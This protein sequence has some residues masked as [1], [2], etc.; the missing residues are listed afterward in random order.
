MPAKGLLIVICGID[1]SG[2]TLQTAMLRDRVRRAGRR[3]RTIEFPRYE[4]GFFGNL[5]ARY[6][7][8][9]F[10]KDPAA[11][12]PYLA[13]LPFAC[14]RW[15]ALPVLD[16]WL[17]AGAV[18]ISNRYVPANLAHQGGKITSRARRREFLQWV[19][20]LEYGVFGL[21][22]PALHVWLDMPPR[23]A[24]TLILRKHKRKYLKSRRDIHESSSKHMLATRVVYKELAG[25]R[26][27]VRIECA[28]KGRPLPP[29]D[30]AE[31]VWQAVCR[32]LPQVRSRR[33]RKE[34][35][36]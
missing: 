24:A 33:Q 27:W 7:R 28:E 21:P 20:K 6:L 13:T 31:K 11:V 10:A 17:K 30:I 4:Q 12:D 18:V 35:K 14:D 26:G 5:V 25:G 36:K 34:K 19:T 29:E 1:G 8:G 23:V 16:G 22:R 15:E 32:R 9:E 3:A 2:K